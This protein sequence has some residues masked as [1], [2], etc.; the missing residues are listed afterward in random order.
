V[1]IETIMKDMEET[2][3]RLNYKIKRYEEAEVTGVL[4]WEKREG[5]M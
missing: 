2:L 3:G 1:E 5:E 4:S